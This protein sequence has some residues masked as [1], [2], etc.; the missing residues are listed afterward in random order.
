[1]YD[2]ILALFSFVMFAVFLAILGIW[3]ESISLKMV[4]IITALMCAYDFWL[5]TFAKRK[6]G[7]GKAGR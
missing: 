2:K 5:S 1:M 4:L 7:N 6:N 3:V